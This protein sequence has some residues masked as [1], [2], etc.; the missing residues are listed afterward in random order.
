MGRAASISRR[1][2][3][4]DLVKRAWF[5]DLISDEEGHID[6]LETPLGLFD[7]LGEGKYGMLNAKPADQVE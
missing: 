2:G 1:N 3:V 6:F 5:D 7:R 4:G